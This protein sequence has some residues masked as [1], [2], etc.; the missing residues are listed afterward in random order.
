MLT[1]QLNSKLEKVI[2][3]SRNIVSQCAWVMRKIM[4]NE[5]FEPAYHPFQEPSSSVSPIPS[6]QYASST[7]PIGAER[8]R[9]S[10]C[11]ESRITLGPRLWKR[12]SRGKMEADRGLFFGVP[13]RQL[14]WREGGW[15]EEM[16]HR[17]FLLRT[18][19]TCLPLPIFH[20]RTRLN[21]TVKKHCK[22][23]IRTLISIENY[24]ISGTCS[25][26]TRRRYKSNPQ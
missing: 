6:S 7:S 21:K 1:P 11:S 2:L 17:Y 19:F 13:S 20:W 18:Y 15:N 10:T 4:R 16:N 23:V 5:L 3:I 9:W 25:A 22:W 8:A 12:C 26:L 14:E 24:L